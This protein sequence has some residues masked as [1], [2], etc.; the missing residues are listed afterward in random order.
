[1]EAINA[2][3]TIIAAGLFVCVL[4]IGIAV[5]VL[6]IGEVWRHGNKG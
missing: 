3:C 4:F 2:F 5:M 6:T 1:M